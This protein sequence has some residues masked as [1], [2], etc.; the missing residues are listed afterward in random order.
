MAALLSLDGKQFRWFRFPVFGSAHFWER[1]RPLQR[2]LGRSGPEMPKKSRKCLPGPQKVSKKS[3]NTP[4]TLSRHSPETLRTLPGLS[5]RLFGDFLGPPLGDVSRLSREF[6]A[7]GNTPKTL[8]RHFPETSR[9]VTETFPLSARK[10][11]NCK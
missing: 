9:I 4:K 1:A 8:S 10:S 6:G 3:W 7:G 11:F 5:P 2:S